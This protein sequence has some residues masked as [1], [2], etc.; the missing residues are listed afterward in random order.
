MRTKFVFGRSV[1][2]LNSFKIITLLVLAGSLAAFTILPGSAS[3][4]D[5]RIESGPTKSSDST[6]V[7]KVD[8]TTDDIASFISGMGTG[9]TGCDAKPDTSKTWQN[10]ANELDT[11]F[12]RINVSRTVKMRAWADSEL[13]NNH[14]KTTVFYPF[15]GPDFLNADIFYPD[16]DQY[17]MIAMEPIGALPDICKMNSDKINEYLNS[18][19]YSLRDIFKRSYFI[20]S[21]MTT[22]L[23]KT[24]VNGA[25]PLISLFIKRTGH[26]IVSME[27]IGIDSTGKCLIIKDPKNAKTIVSGIKIDFLSLSG[28]RTQ[29]VYYLRT[30]ISDDGLAKKPAFVKYLKSLP[31]SHTYLKAASYLMHG[32][33]F[34]AIRNIVFEKSLSILQDDSGI[35][36]RFFN[37]KDWDIKLYGVYVKPKDEFS[38][39]NE[40]EL[41]KAY[42]TAVIKPLP[43]TLGYNWRLGHS[44]M[45]YAVKKAN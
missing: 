39:I 6:K 40:P 27:K 30:D 28:D 16:A 41:E 44:N 35:A 20:T 1:K 33:N 19:N 14:T 29:S 42:K 18:V 17:I 12:A 37:K 2:M 31:Q 38:Y 34:K 26:Q 22:D 21:T 43:Y 24:K 3:Q 4:N 45:L 7:I 8:K 13:V 32:D 25:V 23:N 9:K 36:Y 5:N 15:S 10:F 11:M